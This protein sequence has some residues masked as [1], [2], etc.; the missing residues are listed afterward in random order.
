MAETYICAACGGTFA[1]K[2]SDEEAAAESREVF[3]VDPDTDP[4][5]A[6]V[7]DDCYK[8]IT[9]AFPPKEWL[10]RPC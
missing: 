7:C 10:D 9:T 6:I 4:T 8:A 2:W 3:G 1:T 5:M